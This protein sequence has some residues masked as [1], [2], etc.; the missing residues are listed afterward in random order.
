MKFNFSI[1][2]TMKF[3]LQTWLNA[4]EMLAMMKSEKFLSTGFG[5]VYGKNFE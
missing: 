1:G 5:D 3:E 2:E 4:E